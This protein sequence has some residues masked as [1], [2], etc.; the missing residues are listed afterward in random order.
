MRR[1]DK[2][3]PQALLEECKYKIKMSKKKNW[4]NKNFA[5]DLSDNEPNSG[6]D[7]ETDNDA[8]DNE[9]ENSSN[10]SD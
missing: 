1:N 3:Y 10:K 2:Y 4:L 5:S 8:D 9:S 6:T 7:S